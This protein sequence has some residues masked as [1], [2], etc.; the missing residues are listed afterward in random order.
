M[1]TQKNHLNEMVLLS[2]PKHMFKLIDREKM[3]F[4]AQKFCLTGPMRNNSENIQHAIYFVQKYVS[5]TRK[6]LQPHTTDLL[7]AL[8]GRDGV[9]RN[10]DVSLCVFCKLMRGR[11]DPNTT[12]SRSSMARQ[13]NT[14]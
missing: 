11:E 10:F 12:K 5:M 3:T 13:R 2:N 9:Q 14:I 1:G 6:C 4:Y 7:M 8:R